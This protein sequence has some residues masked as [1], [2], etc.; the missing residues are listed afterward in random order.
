MSTRTWQTYRFQC[1]G[2]FCVATES[3]VKFEVKQASKALQ[4]L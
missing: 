1:L 3:E 2:C 4:S